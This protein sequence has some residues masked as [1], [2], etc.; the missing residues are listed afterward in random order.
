MGEDLD[1]PGSIP[2]Y[3]DRPG[4]PTLADWVRKETSLKKKL[5]GHGRCKDED[6]QKASCEKEGPPIHYSGFGEPVK[7]RL[8]GLRKVIKEG[9]DHQVSQTYDLTTMPYALTST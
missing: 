4:N 1:G 7:Q 9:S 8:N 6:C 5:V 3:W 2:I